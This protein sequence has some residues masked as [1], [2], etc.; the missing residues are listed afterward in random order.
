MKRTY[1]FLVLLAVLSAALFF[2]ACRKDKI[3]EDHTIVY[4]VPV[5]IEAGVH[6]LVADETG[7]PVSNATVFLGTGQTQTDDNGF[8]QIK[9]LMNS[10]VPFVRVEKP[11]YFPSMAS[12]SAKV[13]STGRVK[14]TLRAKLPATQ[15]NASSGGTVDIPG[16]G[17]VKFAAGGFMDASGQPYNGVVQVFA[18]Y[19][20]PSK[21]GIDNL[22]PGGFLGRSAS[23]EN[24]MLTSFGMVHVLLETPAGQKLQINK[25]AEVTM[26]VPTDR[27]SNAPATIPLWYIDEA[28]GYWKE[29]GS[30]TLQGNVYVGS[31]T[32]FS[33]WNC[34]IGSDYIRL[35]GRVR[36]GSEHPYVILRVTQN[37]GLSAT[38]TPD[39][40]GY[41]TGGVPANQT[42]LF[43]AINECG[44]VVY[45]TTLGP[46]SSETDIGI[47]SISWTS[48][49]INVAGS[50]VDCNMQPVTNGFVSFRT[51]GNQ[52]AVFFPIAVDP[53]TGT[54][55][56][57]VVNC[58]GTEVTL[59]A[60]DID[61]QL[62]SDPVT[63]PVSAD[64]D[65]G[66]VTVCDN[67]VAFG[68]TLEFP[69][70]TTKFIPITSATISADTVGNIYQFIANDV[71][72]SGNGAQYT[73]AFLNWTGDPSNPIWGL[74]YQ[75]TIFGAPVYYG[76]E[77]S[78]NNT[79][80]LA[81]GTQPGEM[82]T[83]RLSNMILIEEP[84]GIHYAQCNVTISAILQ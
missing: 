84:S 12:F 26:P 16:G 36:I 18:T 20:D 76:F 30:A 4:P 60:I 69:N 81:L 66:Q 44:E 29:E 73:I 33:W 6:G 72:G 71:Q 32:H 31:V 50:L 58:G 19:L 48:D 22:I 78:S 46:Y 83:F 55:S 62:A 14:V 45:S 70:G 61:E 35:N 2:G 68:M 56:G 13:G 37:S 21:P 15:V 27:L 52:A 24:Q 9:G 74:S 82:V 42:F 49:W 39:A 8:F 75:H 41:F 79:Q 47:I 53:V 10:E 63:L 43:E 17:T 5:F 65:F 40:N 38:T 54:F 1:N 3:I 77:V 64:V 25:P 57:S 7:A 11:G 80:A 34:D 28:T 67:P 23:G 59:K 51:N